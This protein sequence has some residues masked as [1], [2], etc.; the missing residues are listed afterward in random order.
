M[1]AFGRLTDHKTVKFGSGA[2]PK[3]SRVW[4]ILNEFLVTIVLPSILIPPMLSVTQTGSPENNS[5]YSG[6]LK[7]RTILSF[8]TNWS[9]SSWTSSSVI[10]PAFKSLSK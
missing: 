9:I 8:I 4:R 3:F 1:N 10:N 6:A 7:K 2:A 5:L